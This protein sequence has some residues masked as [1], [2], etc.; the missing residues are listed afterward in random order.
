[1]SGIAFTHNL[2]YKAHSI[3]VILIYR[4]KDWEI[5]KNRDILE[6]GF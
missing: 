2:T 6:K 1:M 4:L 5:G 3:Y